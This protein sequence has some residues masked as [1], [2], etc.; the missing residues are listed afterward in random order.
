MKTAYFDNN[1]TTCVADEVFEQTGLNQLDPVLDVDLMLGY[2]YSNALDAFV[3]VYN[4]ASQKYYL[5]NQYPSQRIN[6]LVG[7]TYK[8]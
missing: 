7:V 1:A 6:V 3:N 5:W 8:F 4:L 2:H